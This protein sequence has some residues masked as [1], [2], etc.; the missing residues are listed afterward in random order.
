MKSFIEHIHKS[1]YGPEYYQE[2]L[3]QPSS[4]SWKYYGSL[5]MLLALFLTIVSSISLVPVINKTLYNLPNIFATYYPDELEV[6]IINGHASS[7]VLEPYFL[8]APLM[9]KESL[10]S[11]ASTTPYLGVIDTQTPISLERFQ[12]YNAFFWVSNNALVVRDQQGGIRISP[13][14]PNFN[15]TVNEQVLGDMIR[16]TEPFFKFVAPLV[17]LIVFFGMLLLFAINLI[18]LIFAAIFV[19]IMG[20]FL[21]HKWTY[22]TSFRICLHAATLPLL[23]NVVF[24]LVNLDIGKLPFLSTALLLAVVYF[25]LRNLPASTPESHHVPPSPTIEDSHQS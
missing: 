4:F 19:F 10:G 2:L 24:S 21:K 7:T 16:S 11:N 1:I 12:A 22:G 14:S 8:P 25:S 20:R 23:L 6:R 15:Y 3:T 13:F 5:A 9:L 17:V 18:Y